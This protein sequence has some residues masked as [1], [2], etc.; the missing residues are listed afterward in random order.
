M[1]KLVTVEK[2]QDLP[3]A[4]LA[5]AKLESEGIYCHLSSKH[6]IGLNWQYSLALGGVRLLVLEQDLK[7]AQEI[8]NTD[9]SNLL[10]EIEDT[11]PSPTT[12]DYCQKCG[13]LNLSYINRARFF[14]ALS[15]LSGLPLY[16]FGIRYKC[17]DCGHKMNPSKK[18]I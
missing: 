3:L 2:Y 8:L 7:K 1:S 16:I 14:G 12:D 4:E 6:H 13:S 9:E 18:T 17:K 5:R 15:M 11:F 10:T